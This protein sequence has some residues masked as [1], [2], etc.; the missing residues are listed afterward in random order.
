MCSQKVALLP[1]TTHV[2]VENCLFPFLGYKAFGLK[3]TKIPSKSLVLSAWVL[4]FLTERAQVGL[5]SLTAIS[6]ALE[7]DESAPNPILTCR[8]GISSR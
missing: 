8:T 3:T 1:V 2:F 7:T 4:A 5:F 6:C